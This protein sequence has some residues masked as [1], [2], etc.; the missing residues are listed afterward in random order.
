MKKKKR[1]YAGK[2]LGTVIGLMSIQG[3]TGNVSSGGNILFHSVFIINLLKNIY[4][5]YL[6]ITIIINIKYSE[7]FSNHW[8]THTHTR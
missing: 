7:V 2:S 3:E 1:L 5:S 8:N 4:I 6:Y